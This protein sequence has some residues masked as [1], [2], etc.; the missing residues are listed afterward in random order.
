MILKDLIKTDHI[1]WWN[2]VA[3]QMQVVCN[4]GEKAS[5]YRFWKIDSAGIGNGFD[6]E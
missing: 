5:H 6:D 3:K 2:I 4:L 1:L